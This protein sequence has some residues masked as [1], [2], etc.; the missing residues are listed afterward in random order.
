M[1][2]ACLSRLGA[3]E[4]NQS[5]LDAGFLADATRTAATGSD[6][7]VVPYTALGDFTPVRGVIASQDATRALISAPG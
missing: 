3:T 4:A 5:T 7:V 6:F 1:P 2:C